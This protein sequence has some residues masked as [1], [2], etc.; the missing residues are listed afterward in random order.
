[1][2]PQNPAQGI[3]LT[4]DYGDAM[5]YVVSCECGDSN[6]NHNVW[7]EAEDSN[8]SVTIHTTAKTKWWESSRW[9]HIWT[10]LTKGYVEYEANII[11]TEQQTI[12]YAE[13]LKSAVESSKKF[14]NERKNNSRQS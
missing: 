7:V 13:T 1:M 9:K 10:L 14:A 11:M 5:Q 12:N 6:H 8:V 4:R 3:L 2:K